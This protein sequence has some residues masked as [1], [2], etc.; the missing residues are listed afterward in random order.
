M[1]RI[2]SGESPVR[3]CAGIMNMLVTGEDQ[4][5]TQSPNTGHAPPMPVQPITKKRHSCPTKLL[6]MDYFVSGGSII[7]S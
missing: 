3:G 4:F 5:L 1:R 7:W 2:Y 6:Y